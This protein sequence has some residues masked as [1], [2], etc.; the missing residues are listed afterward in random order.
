MLS[1][2]GTITIN[3]GGGS[4]RSFVSVEGD[5]TLTIDSGVTIRAGMTSFRGS[6]TGTQALINH[7]AIISDRTGSGGGSNFSI[8][9]DQFTNQGVLEASGA[10]TLR[11]L[12]RWTNQGT[13]RDVDAPIW[14]DGTF[15]VDDLGTLDRQGGT[16]AITGTLEN[17]SRTLALSAS[18]GDIAMQLTGRIDGGTVS[19]SDGARLIVSA[20]TF[21]GVSLQAPTTLVNAGTL[22]IENDLELFSQITASTSSAIIFKPTPTGQQRLSGT[23]T[24]TINGGGGSTRSFVSVEGDTTLTIDSGVTIRAG[25]TSFRGSGAGTQALINRG[26]II[27]DRTGSGSGS[28]F[29]IEFDQFTNQGV[30]AAS[31]AGT[32]RL[33]GRWTNEGT[34]RDVGAPIL[35]DGTFDVDDLGTLDRQGGTIAIAG[36]LQN[37]SRTLALSAS[38]GDIAMQ[39]T[40]RIDGGTVSSSDGAQL[41]VSAG[42]FSGVSLQAPTTLVNAGTLNIEND[43]ELFSQ[44]T[45]GTSSAIVVKPAPTGQQLLSGTGTIAINGGGGSTRSVVRIEGDTMLT[46]D[47]GVTIRA[48]MTSFRGSGAGTQALINRGTLIVD[49]HG[50]GSSGSVSFDFLQVLNEGTLRVINSELLII[51]TDLT[52]PGV[53]DIGAGSSMNVSGDLGLTP[54]SDLSFGVAGTSTF[55]RGQLSITGLAVLDGDLN[56][57]FSFSPSTGVAFPVITYGSVDSGFDQLRGYSLAPGIGILADAGA[58]S[59]AIETS[60]V[61]NQPPRAAGPGHAN[62]LGSNRYRCPGER[63]RSGRRFAD[64][65]CCVSAVTRRGFSKPGRHDPISGRSDLR[66]YGHVHL[67]NR[68]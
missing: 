31:G 47:S 54:E 60:M 5:T 51:N 58:T 38:T 22:N 35:L 63:F 30:L 56:A 49:R 16:I 62:R 2:T 42:T 3:G 4:T 14:L 11:L 52:S 12:G 34:M 43:L 67:Q 24:I 29:S 9:F 13:L 66:W 19:S 61:G 21:S 40:G 8:E 25:M 39:L 28:N 33:L 55:Q 1:G 6:G 32:L 23:E 26:S 68:R 7:G 65:H 50:T 15:D 37:D 41:I 57:D 64:R 53:I 46:I 27:S 45:A 10:G 17:D 18:T 36:T 48:G 44:I 20:G 59:L